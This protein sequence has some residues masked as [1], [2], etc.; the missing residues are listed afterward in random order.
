MAENASPSHAADN[1]DSSGTNNS[2]RILAPPKFT[3]RQDTS[4][5]VTNAYSKDNGE[6][7]EV[8]SEE[9]TP[10][11]VSVKRSAEGEDK[12]VDSEPDDGDSFSPV[13]KVAKL[14]KNNHSDSDD[15]KPHK[16]FLKPSLL[17]D[18]AK[19]LAN[20]SPKIDRN[21]TT[22]PVPKTFGISSNDSSVTEQGTCTNTS[23][24]SHE[25]APG[26]NKEGIIGASSKNYFAE[27]LGS[28]RESSTKTSSG[29]FV[30][31]QN[32][33]DRVM[34]SAADSSGNNVETNGKTE[35]KST[36]CD[37]SV[38]DHLGEEERKTL[39]DVAHSCA[40]AEGPR[41]PNHEKPHKS[42]AEA[43]MEYQEHLSP[44][45]SQPAKVAVVT[46]EEEEKNVLQSNC[47][48]FVFDTTTHSWRE[49]GRGVIRLNDMC[50]SMTEG[51][52][53][54]R[55][56]MRTQGSLRVVLNT[57]LWPN[58]TLEKGNEKSLR[59][60]AMD[61]EKDIKIYLIMAAPNDIQRLWTAIDR[62]IQ[63]L[64]RGQEK[65]KAADQDHTADDDDESK[66]EPDDE[67]KGT[68]QE[69]DDDSVKDRCE[70][71][72][73]GSNDS[74]PTTESRGN[75]GKETAADDD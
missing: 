29:S 39:A 15:D 72:D 67:L 34:F 6:E 56:V 50:Q 49:K 14:E 44:P 33:G 4:G 73:E 25:L 41:S 28:G 36:A 53:Q 40:D 1:E 3:L 63:A 64:K 57:K 32:M 17:S 71:P 35:E 42:L 26:Q 18:V 55:L 16:V 37:N 13:K 47:R 62:R 54:S 69:D 45:K 2:V 61:S 70:V 65:E 27:F 74:C 19:N 8:S 52:F 68:E 60:T 30:F 9:S 22:S 43:A 5:K 66:T 31:G 58:M 59:F 11:G 24:R 51:I 48:L 75:E 7:P 38:S 46:G 21:S 20:A 12:D 10:L 23:Q